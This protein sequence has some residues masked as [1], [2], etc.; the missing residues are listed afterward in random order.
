MNYILYVY[1]YV[2]VC[3]CVYVYVYVFFPEPSNGVMTMRVIRPNHG[4]SARESIQ[5]RVMDL[6]VPLLN[7]TWQQH[8]AGD[9]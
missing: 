7:M 1:V 2:C 5:F 4:S 3:V 9:F 6:G 8:L